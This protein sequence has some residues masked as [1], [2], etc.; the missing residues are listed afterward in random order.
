MTDSS[1]PLKLMSPTGQAK[2]HRLSCPIRPSHCG[3]P[4]PP[5]LSQTYAFP[6]AQLIH[7]ALAFGFP[8]CCPSKVSKNA[9]TGKGQ[10]QWKKNSCYC[11][12]SH[13]SSLVKG[14]TFS[15]TSFPFSWS[16]SAIRTTSS[17]LK[18]RR[19]TTYSNPRS[20]FNASRFP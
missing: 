12:L 6:E 7:M 10:A 15:K 19:C 17:T 1:S 4:F 9:A 11:P 3:Y 8:S 18:S 20:C 2:K 14:Y 13:G 16:K 5:G